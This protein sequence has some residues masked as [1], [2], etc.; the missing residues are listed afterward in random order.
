MRHRG[1]TRGRVL[2]RNGQGVEF[3]YKKGGSLSLPGTGYR[4]K[5]S[6][7]HP[8]FDEYIGDAPTNGP[9][10][11]TIGGGRYTHITA[12]GRQHGQRPEGEDVI[13]R[14]FVSR[15]QLQEEVDQ[16]RRVAVALEQQLALAREFRVPL[17]N[18]V[19]GY[20]EITVE[21]DPGLRLWA[22]TDGALSGKRAWVDGDWQRLT[23]IGR[24]AA[25]T[26][27]LDEALELAHQ[28]AEFEGAAYE[29]QVRVGQR[30]D[31]D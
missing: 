6:T 8:F 22:V 21:K 4:V 25:Y 14:R 24:P 29:A 17:P 23:D 16:A 30:P 10:V 2:C 11:R 3:T 5:T 27:P 12:A 19:G 26:H 9:L 15:R 13:G 7:F 1:S 20:G 31:A 28:V 18:Q